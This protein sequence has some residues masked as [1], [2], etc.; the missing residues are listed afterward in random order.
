MD[1]AGISDLAALRGTELSAFRVAAVPGI[2]RVVVV[3]EHVGVAEFERRDVA[4]VDLGQGEVRPLRDI[5]ILRREPPAAEIIIEELVHGVERAPDFR[6]G[7]DEGLPD[8]FQPDA[9][10]SEP[11]DVDPG[12]G[13]VQRV[14]MGVRPDDDLLLRRL[15]GVEGDGEIR[16]G[17]FAEEPF[18]FFRCVKHGR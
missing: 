1:E 4:S 9:L 8:R 10:R 11:G 6:S 2:E 16:S 15:L 14:Q 17:D 18:Q 12:S 7:E 5:G 13:F 3:A